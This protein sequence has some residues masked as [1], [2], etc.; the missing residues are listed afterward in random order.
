[1]IIYDLECEIGH[2]FEGWFKSA[3][4]FQAQNDSHLISCPLCESATIKRV[5]SAHYVKASNQSG[6]QS[7][8][9]P[10][11]SAES[12]AEFKHWLNALRHHVKNSEDV[13]E[14]FSEEA[15]RMHYGEADKRAIKGQA[16]TEQIQSLH[17]EGVDTLSLPDFLLADKNK[18]N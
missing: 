11:P 3:D 6:N 12:P 7:T 8:T 2:R 4:D 10:I 9:A 1:M 17:E 14:R 15:R 5:P 13:G 16:T 18:L